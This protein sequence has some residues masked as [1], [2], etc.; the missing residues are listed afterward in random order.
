[1]IL[2]VLIVFHLSLFFISI[3][4]SNILYLE[5]YHYC[6]YCGIKYESEDELRKQC[7][8]PFLEDH[9]ELD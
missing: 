3:K 5:T 7:P 2:H 1:M 4:F 9:D 8:G 6:I